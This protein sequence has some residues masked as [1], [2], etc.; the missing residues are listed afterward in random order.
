MCRCAAISTPWGRELG[1]WCFGIAFVMRDD[2]LHGA[3]TRTLH[4]WFTEVAGHTPTRWASLTE[5]RSCHSGSNDRR[6][7]E[8]DDAAW[9]EIDRRPRRVVTVVRLFVRSVWSTTSEFRTAR[10]SLV[11]RNLGASDTPRVARGSVDDMV[12]ATRSAGSAVDDFATRMTICSSTGRQP[13][14][15]PTAVRAPARSAT[16]CASGRR[17]GVESSYPQQITPCLYPI[18]P[19]SYPYVHTFSLSI[20]MTSSPIL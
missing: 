15:S 2:L 3:G 12:H 14:C 20:S 19:F 9:K 17:T 6:L 5:R 8:A 13:R 1:G 10:I 11:A 4:V 18:Y 16:C 7:C